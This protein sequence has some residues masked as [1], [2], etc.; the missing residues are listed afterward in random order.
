MLSRILSVWIL[1]ACG[2]APGETT[3]PVKMEV[4]TEAAQCDAIA[5][6]GTACL[7]YTQAPFPE[8][9]GVRTPDFALVRVTGTEGASVVI[10]AFVISP[11]NQQW[12]HVRRVGSPVG[13]TTITDVLPQDVEI[14]VDDTAAAGMRA[15]RFVGMILVTAPGGA[16]P[17]KLPVQLTVGPDTDSI[18]ASPDLVPGVTVNATQNPQPVRAS[19]SMGRNGVGPPFSVSVIPDTSDGGAWLNANLQA[20][21][22]PCSTEPVPCE[23]EAIVT[24]PQ[25]A[26]EYWG[27]LVIVS[28]AG[29]ADRVAVR[30]KVN[31]AVGENPP[32]IDPRIVTLSAPLGSTTPVTAQV[33]LTGGYDDLAFRA[34]NTDPWLTVD[35]TAARWPA[36]LKL[37]ANPSGLDAG[38]YSEVVQL[39]AVE[40]NELLGT[41]PVN[42]TITSPVYLPALRQSSALYLINPG[43]KEIKAKVRFW[44]SAR[45]QEEVVPALGMKVIAAPQGWAEVTA[46]GPVSA[47]AVLGE[48]RSIVAGR[49]VPVDATVP[50]ANALRDRLL[51]P[52]DNL[53]DASVSLSV[54]NP[55]DQPVTVDVG[56]LN[57]SGA[58][59]AKEGNFTLPG[60]GAATFELSS[61]W[62]STAT[63]RG[64]LSLDFDGRKLLVTGLRT[65]GSSLYAYPAIARGEPSPERGIA[66]VTAGGA[67]YL[68]NSTSLVQNGTLRLWAEAP[69]DG[70]REESALPVPAD[71]MLVWQASGSGWLESRYPKQVGGF[72][73]LRQNLVASGVSQRFESSV[74]G[75]IGFNGRLAIP[76]DYRGANSTQIVLV[77]TNDD[78]TEIQTVIYDLGG[79]FPRFGET[80]K[81][82]GKEQVSIDGSDRWEL[83]GQQGIVVFASRHSFRLSGVGLR[84]GDGPTAVLPAFGK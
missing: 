67:A 49:T 55:E 76:F 50:L 17:V 6:A 58:Q 3:T 71:G 52:F 33:T 28:A 7:R 48:T 65:Q 10:Q 41:I 19:I 53:G 83:G 64:L 22:V 5:R 8:T 54:A 32:T 80:F 38:L 56:V 16:S 36:V 81:L 21:F 37:T 57:E 84:S 12:L 60:R 78:P 11:G 42:F 39:R 51:L 68:A 74:T 27:V 15:G 9:G 18:A 79:R 26:G 46:D 40:T 1:I 25:T 2:L 75:G 70:V 69:Q 61:K 4:R 62:R 66:R 13:G 31:P 14:Y 30:V 47:Y 20:G 35:P 44:P 34:V 72:L 77:N 63:R 29:Y 82:A 24:P 59:I 23:F 45:A 73:L 43:S